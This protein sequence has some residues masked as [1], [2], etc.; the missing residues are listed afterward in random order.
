MKC[1]CCERE[2]SIVDSHIISN[3]IRK[4]ITGIDTP[5][6]KKFQF[7]YVGRQDLPKQ[8]LPKPKLLCENCDS[9]FGSLI[10]RPAA[11]VLIPTGD[12][13]SISVWNQLPLDYVNILEIGGQPLTAA[14]YR[15]ENDVK[16]CA[17]FKF[18]VLTAWRALH[19]MNANGDRDAVD[20]LASDEG[21]RLQESTIHFLNKA[22]HTNFLH[23][24]YYSQLYLFGPRSAA[25]ISGADD[26]VPFAWTIVRSGEQVGIAVILGYWVIL[27]SLLSDYDPRSNFRELL[28][29]TFVDWHAKVNRSLCSSRSA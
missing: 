13:T 14:Q 11:S 1:I 21:Q 10:E 2:G 9:K 4:A 12:L 16:E 24:P 8:D 5:N 18:K 25:T 27:W 20:Y 17:L 7:R 23:F 6:G 3:F 29:P 22:D 19:A 28:I 26:E 15:V